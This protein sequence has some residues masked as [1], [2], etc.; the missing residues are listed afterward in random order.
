[1]TSVLRIFQI[2][3]IIAL[4]RPATP[5]AM[6]GES[7]APLSGSCLNGNG[8][9]CLAREDGCAVESPEVFCQACEVIRILDEKG[10]LD[11]S[12]P[13]EEGYRIIEKH[14]SSRMGSCEGL[15]V[16]SCHCD[17]AADKGGPGCSPI[18]DYV[19]IPRPATEETA[20]VP[21]RLS[22]SAGDGSMD[23]SMASRRPAPPRQPLMQPPA[24]FEQESFYGVNQPQNDSLNRDDAPPTTKSDEDLQKMAAE[25][26]NLRTR[27]DALIRRMEGLKEDYDKRASLGQILEKDQRAHK[28]GLD[29]YRSDLYFLQEQ[30]SYLVLPRP[31]YLRQKQVLEQKH[32][33]ERRRLMSPEKA[34]SKV[35][36]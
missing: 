33:E 1:M 29:L 26:K 35:E 15:S 11:D 24:T 2:L 9:I 16:R 13:K 18:D 32:R 36:Q 3:T 23:R 31:E 8:P 17:A 21:Q 10:L 28:K 5:L 34:D 6:A 14:F 20:P 4:F 25:K 30:E 19:Y 12:C 7:P 27:Q 22:E